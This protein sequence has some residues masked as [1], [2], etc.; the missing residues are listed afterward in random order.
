MNK[1][2]DK[3]GDLWKG[4]KSGLS[5][6]RSRISKYNVEEIRWKT[7]PIDGNEMQEKHLHREIQD[8]ILAG[9]EQLISLAN[10]LEPGKAS[11]LIFRR[12]FDANHDLTM[13]ING[14][15]FLLADIEKKKIKELFEAKWPK[16]AVTSDERERKLKEIRAARASAE[17]EEE[18]AIMEL[19]T[20]GV[21][22]DRRSDETPETFLEWD[23]KSFNRGKLEN[24]HSANLAKQAAANEVSQA[25]AAVAMRR[26]EIESGLQRATLKS[27]EERFQKELDQLREEQ[28]RLTAKRDALEREYRPRRDLFNACDQFLREKNLPRVG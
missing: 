12:T 28:T 23:G 4:F 13:L 11:P 6:I 2:G 27:D 19:E 3:L 21:S 5:D 10:E 17:R 20:Q 9:E 26:R 15:H 1:L 7:R 24:F 22:V 18:A 25:I 14:L 16:D 8:G